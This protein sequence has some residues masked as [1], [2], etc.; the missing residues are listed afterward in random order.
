MHL[1]EAA[2]GAAVLRYLD[3]AL[4][5]LEERRGA[6]AADAASLGVGDLPTL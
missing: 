6:L 5:R 4:R 1:A 3:L 2:Y